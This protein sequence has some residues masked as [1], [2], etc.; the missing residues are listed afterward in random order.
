MAA[1]KWAASRIAREIR[2]HPSTVGWYMYKTGLR[3]PSYNR[4]RTE[5]YVR[6]GRMIYPYLALEDQ[7]IVE[8]RVDG[9]SYEAIAQLCSARFGRPRSAH[10]INV[11]LTM[12]AARD[13]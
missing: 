13:E 12:L 9:L 8:R 10:G 3:A 1:R 2:K 7:F 5:P 4:L 11:R 6:G